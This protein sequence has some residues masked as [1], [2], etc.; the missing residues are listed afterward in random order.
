[1]PLFC[2][3]C[4]YCYV[5]RYSMRYSRQHT[6]SKQHSPS[7]S[8]AIVTIFCAISTPA[9]CTPLPAILAGLTG[10]RLRHIHEAET[11]HESRV[12]LPTGIY[13]R[14]VWPSLMATR[15]GAR[16][17]QAKKNPQP[18]HGHG[19]FDKSNWQEFLCN[20]RRVFTKKNPRTRFTGR[21]CLCRFSIAITTPILSSRSCL[22]DAR[23]A[24]L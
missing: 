15:S 4:M 8:R 14:V 9:L 22:S 17:K 18:T 16:V 10:S 13:S 1:M 7:F 21:G 20:L 2:S 24:Q 3:V 11:R 5:C 6:T 19:F 23:C 12:S